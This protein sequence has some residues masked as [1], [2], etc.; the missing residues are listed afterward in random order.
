[1]CFPGHANRTAALVSGGR[2]HC[3]GSL[4]ICVQGGLFRQQGECSGSLWGLSLSLSLSTLLR[5][6]CVSSILFVGKIRKRESAVPCIKSL[7]SLKE[8]T[9]GETQGNSQP[10]SAK[11]LSLDT[12][13]SS[14]SRIKVTSGIVEEV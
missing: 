10:H 7:S 6:L 12:E 11:E 13:E 8:V 1:M 5:S 4:R 3:S 9:Q 2:L 14:F